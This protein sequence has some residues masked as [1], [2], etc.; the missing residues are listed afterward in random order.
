MI[1]VCYVF[2]YDREKRE[3]ALK[4]LLCSLS[5]ILFQQGIPNIH[6]LDAS[7]EKVNI[8]PHYENLLFR[9]H[10]PQSGSFNKAVLMN[11]L[12]KNY[13]ADREYCI[14]A[15]IDII[16]EPDYIKKMEAYTQGEPV[17]VVGYNQG[18]A[19][20]FLTSDFNE[21]M[22]LIKE[23]GEMSYRCGESPGLGLLHIPSFLKI[24][25]FNEEFKEYGPEDCELNRRL[26]YINKYIY[27]KD[28][29]NIHLY[30]EQNDNNFANQNVEIYNESE[31]RFQ[32]GDLVRN[33]DKWGEY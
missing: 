6:I 5:S 27:D 1:P 9:F 28:I 12:I 21:G 23:K 8:P 22:R 20:E 32:S 29:V 19:H 24:R 18:A 17:R 11:H 3:K 26:A 25:G 30:H 16:F 14:L 4:R 33:N 13:L 10:K 31:K 15:D 7:S 2:R